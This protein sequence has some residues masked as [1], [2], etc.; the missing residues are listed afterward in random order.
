MITSY[1][2]FQ[3][4][5]PVF[6]FWNVTP[7]SPVEFY[8]SI[9]ESGKLPASGP[10]MQHRE[11]P[12]WLRIPPGFITTIFIPSR[13][14]PYGLEGGSLTSGEVF[15]QF[16]IAQIYKTLHCIQRSYLGAANCTPNTRATVR[17][18]TAYCIS[19]ARFLLVHL[20]SDECW[21]PCAC[22]LRVHVRNH[23]VTHGRRTNAENCAVSTD[24]WLPQTRGNPVINIGLKWSRP[25][26]NPQQG[27]EELM[28]DL[29]HGRDVFEKVTV[30]LA[31]Q[32]QAWTVFQRWDRGFESH[33]MHGC[34][35]CVRSLCV[36]VLY[37][38]N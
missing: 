33:S 15:E 24:E 29:I 36:C 34:L 22:C 14:R 5:K 25:K 38:N 7:C 1:S 21:W 31:A 28:L 18:L 20:D 16:I 11:Q 23:V 17:N 19:Y 27:E 37:N 12:S 4:P 6:T 8:R 3:A 35:K 30:T 9:R 13:R 32:S 2:E 26:T 10:R